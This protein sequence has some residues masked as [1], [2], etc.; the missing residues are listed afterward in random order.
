MNKENLIFCLFRFLSLKY[1]NLKSDYRFANLNS[2]WRTRNQHNGT[3]LGME[4]DIDRVEVGNYTYGT[5]N[6]HNGR[7]S[8]KIIIGNFCSVASDVHFFVSMDHDINCVSTYPFRRRIFKKKIW[9]GKGHGD[10]V[11]KDDV[12]LG[13]GVKIMSGVTIAQGAVIGAG[14]V[15]TKDIPP[16]AVAGG[17]T[18]TCNKVQISRRYNR[19][20]VDNRF[21]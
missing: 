19:Q 6:I 9:E 18:R 21:F 10:I 20:T 15:V 3:L 13:T 2:R 5:L 8:D 7:G 16:Y 17:G 12:W 1:R 11:I 4:C 14:A